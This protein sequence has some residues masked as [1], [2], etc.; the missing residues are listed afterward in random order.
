MKCKIIQI[1]LGNYGSTG[2]IMSGIS[3]TAIKEGFDVYQAYPAGS[4]N[5]FKYLNDIIIGSVFF[6]KVNQKL[7]YYTSYNGCFAVF[8]T[9]KFLHKVSEIEP[10]IIHLHNLHNSYINIPLLFHYIKKRNISVVWTL[11]DCWAMTGQCPHFTLA[12][13]DKWKTGCYDCSQTNIYPRSLV[14]NT[15]I[16]WKLKKKWFTGVKNIAIV[17]PSRWLADMVKQSFLKN[18][19]IK[20]IN[21]GIDLSIFKP[22]PSNYRKKYGISDEKYIVLGVAFDWG[23][24]KGLDIFVKLSEMLD[25]RFQIILV[26]ISDNIDELVKSNMIL[27][28]RTQNFKELAE[29]YTV[30]DVFVNPTRE[31][32]YP[33]VNMEALAC[34]TPVITFRTGGSPEIINGSCGSAVDVDDVDA[35]KDEIVKVC[36]KHTFSF[37]ECINKA[38]SFDMNAKYKEY[39]ELYKTAY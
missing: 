11:H 35:L 30:A 36:V 12:K 5:G 24:R 16:M 4:I 31:E 26:G 2:T 8:S 29:I 20:V 33:S 39:L 23:K 10:N 15:K 3:Q 28:Q 18:Y 14:D 25:N 6:K 37:S 32:N 21:N 13:C 27:I 22:T 1:N 34:G 19:P 7:A 17:T 38:N 9:L